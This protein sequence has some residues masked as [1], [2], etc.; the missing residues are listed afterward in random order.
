MVTPKEVFRISLNNFALGFRAFGLMSPIGG[1]ND[2]CFKFD[3]YL[4]Y[5]VEVFYVPFVILID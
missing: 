1:A 4:F 3:M 5:F 2:L